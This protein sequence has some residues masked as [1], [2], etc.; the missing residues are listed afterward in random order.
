[1]ASFTKATNGWRAQV[2]RLGVRASKVF[3]TRDQAEGWADM[4]ERQILGKSQ[5]GN[6]LKENE[7]LA[8]LFPRRVLAAIE[9]APVMHA[10]IVGAAVEVPDVCG[11]YFL[12][13]DGEVVYVGKSRNVLQRLTKHRRNGKRFDAYNVYHCAPENLDRYERLYITALMPV[14]NGSLGCVDTRPVDAETAAQAA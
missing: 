11:V 5:R 9:D 13:R 2:A 6:V 8:S 14:E 3:P 10:E 7:F 1:M 4:M 12:I